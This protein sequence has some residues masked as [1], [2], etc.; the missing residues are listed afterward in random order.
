MAGGAQP[1]CRASQLLRHQYESGGTLGG[2]TW[3]HGT[4]V[5]CFRFRARRGV[6]NRPSKAVELRPL[7]SSLF[8]RSEPPLMSTSIKHLSV[9]DLEK[10]RETFVADLYEG[11]TDCGFVVLRDHGIAKADLEKAYALIKAF[12]ALPVETKLKYD[13][14]SGGARGY[15]AFGRENAAGNPHSDLKE[16]WHVGQELAPTSPYFGI[17][18]PNRWPEELPEFKAHMLSIYAQLE[19]LEIFKEVRQ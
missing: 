12:F 8:V 18:E 14:G 4:A 5:K 3:A 15:T 13:S 6:R 16:F 9:H 7:S 17:Y 10:D 19:A 2:G 1:S 11:L